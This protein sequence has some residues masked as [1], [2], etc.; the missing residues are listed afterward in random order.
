[1]KRLNKIG[2]LSMVFVLIF[3]F[4]GIS[5]HLL[6]YNMSVDVDFTKSYEYLYQGGLKTE[7]DIG[8]I[9]PYD[10]VRAR[11]GKSVEAY[12]GKNYRVS[13]YIVAANGD[14][15]SKSRTHNAKNGATWVYTD[16]AEV[17]GVDTAKRI[18]Y[19][20]DGYSIEHR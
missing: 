12:S 17:P 1:M 10:D 8:S 14:T 7:Y 11:S 16:W 9:M 20:F 4:S 15:R 2:L 6:A 13:V 19:S 18:V 3:V 5:T